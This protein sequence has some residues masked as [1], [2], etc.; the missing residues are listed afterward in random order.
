MTNDERAGV[1]GGTLHMARRTGSERTRHIPLLDLDTI[2]WATKW[3]T[4]FQAKL[5]KIH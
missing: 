3:I 2:L 5:E 4:G 1:G